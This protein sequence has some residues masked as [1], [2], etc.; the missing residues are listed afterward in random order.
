MSGYISEIDYDGG[1]G[2]NF[3]EIVV[4]ASIDASAYTLVVYDKDGT[5]VE[6]F[7]L[8]SPV[9]TVAGKN[10]YLIDDN[11]ANWIDLKN[12]DA[13]ALVDDTGTVQQ[14]IA[15]K[16]PV[17]AVEGP[18][19]GQSATQ[20]GEHSGGE[21]SLVTSD[22][23]GSYG[24]TT[25]SDP[26]VIPCY[27]TG[28]LIKTPTGPRAIETLRPGDRVWTLDSGPQEILWVSAR[29][30]AL[31]RGRDDDCPILIPA[32]ALGSDQP[33]R[34]LI[35]SPQHRIL[36]GGR[37]AAVAGV[38]TEC[39]V[40][41]KA[42]LVLPGIRRMRGKRQILWH[43]FACAHHHVVEAVGCF[44]ESLLLGQMVLNSLGREELARLE[45]IFG[46][47]REDGPWNGPAARPCI[48]AGQ[49][50][51]LFHRARNGLPFAA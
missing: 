48:P 44:S 47:R 18:A 37:G 7:S 24:T 15:F 21:E 3:V 19:A 10:V 12:S 1:A 27:A 50:Q 34:D 11:T 28:T 25:T 31:D 16:D 14:F 8:G 38:T 46:S 26:G 49:A 4:P 43:H 39:L 36:V 51:R 9:N 13:L 23:G 32:G 29:A 45:Q 35:V 42:L 41:A 6:T 30:V 2:S 5:I 20:I 40:P 33:E 17:T 22:G